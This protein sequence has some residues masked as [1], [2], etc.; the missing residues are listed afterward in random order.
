MFACE[1]EKGA[2]VSPNAAAATPRWAEDAAPSVKGSTPSNLDGAKVATEKRKVNGGGGVGNLRPDIARKSPL[3]IFT[4]TFD[5]LRRAINAAEDKPARKHVD[6]RRKQS[7]R[8]TGVEDKPDEHATAG[9]DR[10]SAGGEVKA[11]E[12]AAKAGVGGGEVG[13]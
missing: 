12:D 11:E 8:E 10:L 7:H 9:A 3:E 13:E 1:R 6:D 2:I 4:A 5:P